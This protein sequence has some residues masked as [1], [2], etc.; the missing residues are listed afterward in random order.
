MPRLIIFGCIIGV[1]FFG[2]LAD[3]H[4]S[5]YHHAYIGQ[6]STPSESSVSNIALSAAAGQHNFKATTALQWSVGGAIGNDSAVSFGLGKQ[7][8]KVFVSGN[9]SSDGKDSIIGLSAG[10]TF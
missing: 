5:E 4:G 2:M 7:M 9:Y 6:S 3:S 8:G 1:L 10:G